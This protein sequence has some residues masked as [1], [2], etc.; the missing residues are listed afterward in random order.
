M[1]CF[2]LFPYCDLFKVVVLK[3]FE[4]VL[5]V[6]FLQDVGLYESREE[7]VSREEVLGRLDQV[8]IYIYIVLRL[9]KFTMFSWE[10]NK[11]TFNLSLFCFLKY[12]LL[13]I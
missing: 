10:F 1:V 2:I 4:Y 8:E 12:V 3:I 5:P 11:A 6:Q 7:A 13:I 9:L